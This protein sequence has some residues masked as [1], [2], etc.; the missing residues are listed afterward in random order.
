MPMLIKILIN[1]NFMQTYIFQ[2]HFSIKE[3][4][5]KKISKILIRLFLR[6]IH[7]FKIIIIG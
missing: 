6:Y 7:T 1:K 4:L 2:W 3:V 5:I